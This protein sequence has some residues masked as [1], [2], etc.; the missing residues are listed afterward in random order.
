VGL[1]IGRERDREEE[2]NGWSKTFEERFKDGL[3]RGNGI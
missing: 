3:R 1:G 2:M